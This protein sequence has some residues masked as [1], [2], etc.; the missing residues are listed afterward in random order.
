MWKKVS[1]ITNLL[2]GNIRYKMLDFDVLKSELNKYESLRLG[3]GV[4]TE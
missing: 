2:K 4:K 1:L 3:I